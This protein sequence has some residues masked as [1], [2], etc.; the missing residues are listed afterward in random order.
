MKIDEQSIRVICRELSVCPHDI[1][2][3]TALKK[4]ND[5]SFFLFFDGGKKYII[6]IPGEG[7]KELINKFYESSVYEALKDS[8]ICDHIYVND[9]C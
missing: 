6:R 1:Y 3:V 5:E 9:G 7:T 4:R 2:N 8:G